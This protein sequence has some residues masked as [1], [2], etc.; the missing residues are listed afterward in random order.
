MF[1]DGLTLKHSIIKSVHYP[2]RFFEI[3]LNS[4]FLIFPA[5]RFIFHFKLIIK[6]QKTKV[7]NKNTALSL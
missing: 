4:V 6:K 7:R 3:V 5:N 2:P 1:L